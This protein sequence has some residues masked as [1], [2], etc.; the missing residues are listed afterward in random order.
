MSDSPVLFLKI[1]NDSLLDHPTPLT[2]PIHTLFRSLQLRHL[3]MCIS[4]VNS[5]DTEHLLILSIRH[6]NSYKFSHDVDVVS[7]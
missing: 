2:D 3:R 7:K 4:Y 5:S 6:L 1:L